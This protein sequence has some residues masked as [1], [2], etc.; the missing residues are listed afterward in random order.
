MT[1]LMNTFVNIKTV[2]KRPA[3]IERHN[4]LIIIIIIGMYVPK[5]T[6]AILLAYLYFIVTDG[7]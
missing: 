7:C 4:I 3:L 5:G 2:I 1:N 6:L